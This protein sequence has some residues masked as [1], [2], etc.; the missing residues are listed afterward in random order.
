MSDLS[1]HL[2]P[3]VVAKIYDWWQ[4]RGRSQKPRQ[5]LG[6]SEIG[7]HCE[8]YLWYK[9]R[10]SISEQF[11][12]RLYRLFDRGHKEEARFVEE[13]RGIGCEVHEFDSDGKQFEIVALDGHF[14]GHADGVALG[15]PGA[16]R[17]WHLL[18]FK[19]ASADRF[20]EVAKSGV[21]KAQPQHYAQMQVYMHHLGLTRALYLV[22]SKNDD[23]LYAERIRYDG[24]VAE[25]LMRR[26]ERIIRSPEAPPRPYERNDYYLC[27]WCAARD[28]C[29]GL[30]TE[31]VPVHAIDC[32]QCCHATPKERGKW[33]CERRQQYGTVCDKH[34]FLP[35]FLEPYGAPADATETSITYRASDG[36]EFTAGVGEDVLTSRDLASMPKD[37]LFARPATD[38]GGENDDN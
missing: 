9:F 34:L 35:S 33:V 5:Y 17:T 25:Q 38:A 6:G 8:R 11:D 16:E 29:W 37:L 19:T 27:K 15:I 36:Y 21:E 14:R 24:A 20:A 31:A 18:E 1:Q 32:R 13:L 2:Q 7:H 26:A 10:N 28:L 4:Q 23:Q 30:G 3:P 22:V 12:G